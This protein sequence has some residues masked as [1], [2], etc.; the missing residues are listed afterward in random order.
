[1]NEIGV[2]LVKRVKRVSTAGVNVAHHR[3]GQ[4]QSHQCLVVEAVVDPSVQVARATDDRL[5]Q[6]LDLF[7]QRDRCE[8]SPS[9]AHDA[10]R[11]VG[12]AGTG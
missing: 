2:P 12:S 1:M 3:I 7:R 4:L 8:S 5:M 10:S 9:A 11:F 6:G